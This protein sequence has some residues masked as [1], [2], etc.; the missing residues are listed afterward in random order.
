M[1]TFGHIRLLKSRRVWEV[2]AEPHV[3]I[4]LKRV[5]PQ[6]DVGEFGK[7]HLSDTPEHGRELLWFIDR[8]PVEMA[9]AHRAHLELQSRTFIERHER[10][11]AIVDGKYTARPFDLALPLRDY[12]KLAAELGL[13]AGSLLIGDDLGLGKTAEAI[14]ILADPSARPALVVTLTHLPGQWER[15]IKK[16]APSLR[17]HVLKSARP[18]DPE[19]PW[20][21]ILEATRPR[22]SRRDATAYLLPDASD[23]PDVIIS[24]YR[25]LAGWAD[26]LAGLVRGVF[27]DE[28]QELRIAGSDKYRAASHIA[29]AAQVKIGMSATPVYNYGSEIYSVLRVLNP[30]ALGT[31]DE[32]LREWCTGATDRASYPVRDPKALGV[33][34]RE[35]SLML[36]RTRKEV[37]RELPPI[38]P[39][40]HHIDADEEP[41]KAVEGA[42]AELARIILTQG[43]QKRGEKLRAS[44][45]LS[46][47]LRQATGIAKAPHVAALVRML[48]EQGEPVLLYGWHREVYAIWQ[49]LLADLRPVM[50]T[51]SESPTQKQRAFEAFVKGEA[52]VLIMSLRA[53]AGLDGLQEA[54]HVVV[55]GELDWS[56]KVHD[57]GIGR[58]RRDG[59]DESTVVYWALTNAGSDPVVAGVLGLKRAQAEGIVNPYDPDVEPLDVHGGEQN[60]R[61]LAEAYLRQRGLPLPAAAPATGTEG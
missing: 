21:G 14:G 12:Q 15:E 56:P 39:V 26:V 3:V 40:F 61:K 35:Q 8:Y 55:N 22:R 27:F 11:N 57:Q 1:R 60:I 7:I 58:V 4:R 13:Q 16:F 54:C 47:R 30:L 25:K 59:Q 42:A 28:V 51:G 37:G 17:T 44:E 48:V 18:Y 53:G 43:G 41:L 34:L 49:D 50:F 45:E 52:K 9:P 33:Y 23:V 38:I 29:D 19:A 20:G 36:R 6:L 31:R 32:F 46:W 24:N 5:F 2:E 10:L